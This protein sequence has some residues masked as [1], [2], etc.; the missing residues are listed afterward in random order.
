MVEVGS[1]P[2]YVVSSLTGTSQKTPGGCSS[3]I[4][5]IPHIIALILLQVLKEQFPGVRL[6]H[7]VCSVESLP[8][9]TE[10]LVAGTF[11]SLFLTCLPTHFA[12]LTDEYSST[13]RM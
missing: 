12:P 5:R 8:E 13:A 1:F 10:L 9:D 7:D 2:R 6:S 3:I 11:I 4:H